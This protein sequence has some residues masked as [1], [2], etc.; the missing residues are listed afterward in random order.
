MKYPK[1]CIHIATGAINSGS[2]DP[3]PRIR[4]TKRIVVGALHLIVLDLAEQHPSRVSGLGVRAAAPDNGGG[5]NL[6]V[7][8]NLADFGFREAQLQVITEHQRQ[9]HSC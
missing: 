3:E 4:R 1:N 5:T 6:A 9:L 8:G 2:G 7:G